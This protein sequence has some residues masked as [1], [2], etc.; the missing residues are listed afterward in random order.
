MKFENVNGLPASK[1]G[2]NSDK[3]SRL[4]HVWSKINADI[5]SLV[6]TKIN[7]SLLP[8][9]DSLYAIMF[10]NDR[11]MSTISTNANELIGKMQQGEVTTS[12]KSKMLN[13][14]RQQELTPQYSANEITLA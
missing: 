13:A 1:S 2:W 7:Q 8:N 14:Q 12:V 11:A 5:M 9:T 10:L 6:E 3:V 4:R